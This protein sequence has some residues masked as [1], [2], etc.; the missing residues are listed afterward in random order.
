MTKLMLNF[1]RKVFEKITNIHIAET[2]WTA[3]MQFV[4]FGLVGFSNTV[5][6]YS[7]Y[8]ILVFIG[9]NQYVASISGFFASV[10]NAFYWNNNFV[11][12]KEEYEER[13]SVKAF[14]KLLV[15]YAVTGLV[16]QNILLWLC[17]DKF[18]I[19]P[20]IAPIIILFIT[21]PLNF[22]L[23]KFWSFTK[24]DVTTKGKEC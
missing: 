7:V 17:T 23:N 22:V 20:Y 8:C 6:S 16:L 21:I 1:L 13:S 18:G 12:R 15:C 9:V 2:K 19:N 3:F 5:I 4:M 24:N 10:I 11:F 14:I